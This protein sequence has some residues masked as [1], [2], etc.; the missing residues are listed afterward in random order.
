MCSGTTSCTRTQV[1]LSSAGIAAVVVGTTVGV[2][3]AVKH[4]HHTLQGCVF[5]DANGLKLR[6]RDAK[7]HTLKGDAAGIKVGDS[8]KV[9]GSKVKKAKG[10]STGDQVF[11]VQK[12]SKDYRPCP[13][14]VA[15]SS[16]EAADLTP[17]PRAM[18]ARP[19]PV[20]MPS[21]FSASP[22]LRPS[23]SAH[24]TKTTPNPISPRPVATKGKRGFRRPATRALQRGRRR[25]ISAV[26]ATE[27]SVATQKVTAKMRPTLSL[28]TNLGNIRKT[29]INPKL[30]PH[31]ST[32]TAAG[33]RYPLRRTRV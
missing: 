1:V 13:V 2:T 17:F 23:H 29:R 3:Y 26:A 30:V 6:T 32:K 18:R 15:T 4:H 20:M 21:S 19:N 10:D 12:L 31:R 24:T 8:V 28:N 27:I 9:H 7:A 11:V 22:Q 5:S 14:N 16:I 25:M 33:G